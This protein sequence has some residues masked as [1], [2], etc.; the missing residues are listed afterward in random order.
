[1]DYNLLS[2]H[3]AARLKVQTVG[4]IDETAAI[5]VRGNLISVVLSMFTH[6]IS[7][8]I[9]LIF[10]QNLLNSLLKQEDTSPN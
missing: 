9:Y 7:T 6:I 3:M 4:S 1:M 8:T 10:Q 2:N 5:T